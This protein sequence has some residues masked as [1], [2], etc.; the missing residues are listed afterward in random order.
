MTEPPAYR[1][2]Y[3]I[4]ARNA[5]DAVRLYRSWFYRLGL[6][7]GIAAL[8]VGIVATLPPFDLTIFGA[9]FMIIGISALV[10]A[11]WLGPERWVTARN[12]R[13]V[14]GKSVE[15]LFSADGIRFVTPLTNG[16]M[17]WTAVTGIRWNDRTVIGLSDR[18]LVW[19]APTSALGTPEKQAETIAF[20]QRNIVDANLAIGRIPAGAK[21]K[22][23]GK[24]NK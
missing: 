16:F 17:P 23:I 3:E 2:E 20:M 7:L 1:I 18:M 14:I 5:V 22:E 21:V 15:Y 11:F 9:L 8:A 12:A 19:Y 24:D 4:T 6:G 10:G 13:G